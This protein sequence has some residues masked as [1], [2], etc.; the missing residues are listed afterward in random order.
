MKSVTV[1][2]VKAT[3]S[4][5]SFSASV[6]LTGGANTLTAVVTS[7]GGA[8][9]SASEGVTLAV[10]PRATTSSATGVTATRAALTGSVTPGTAGTT[11]QFEYGTTTAYGKSSGTGALTA[12]ASSSPVSLSVTGLSPNATYHFRL[13][14]TSSAGKSEGNDV[15]FK[16]PRATPSRISDSV[17]PHS[18][19]TAPFKYRF[20]GSITLPAGVSP[21]SACKGAV[22]V[23]VRHGHKKVMSRRLKVNR[24]C[25]FSGKA[26]FKAAKLH[27]KGKLTFSFRFDGNGVLAAK[28]GKS[29]AVRFG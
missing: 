21:V 22:A 24:K 29:H 16:T 26:S 9:A 4:G 10:A 17:R 12:S 14:A 18:D 23:T 20:G 11:Y 3:V 6:P 8:S 2:G 7:N 13:V 27:G 19:H 5:G 25:K 15:T 1:N 28:N